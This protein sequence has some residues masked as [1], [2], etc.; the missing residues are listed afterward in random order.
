MKTV[1]FFF[2]DSGWQKIVLHH[3]ADDK[4]ESFLSG[5]YVQFSSTVM[6]VDD[7]DW[8]EVKYIRIS[9]KVL[10]IGLIRGEDIS[11]DDAFDSKVKYHPKMME[12]WFISEESDVY[13]HTWSEW[14][15]FWFVEKKARVLKSQYY[16]SKKIPEN[17]TVYRMNGNI[18]LIEHQGEWKG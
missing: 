13:E 8:N 4:L 11:D 10:K 7:I 3:I 12:K 6:L 9:G 2:E 15:R 18:K 14:K 16:L 1:A 5:R 17:T